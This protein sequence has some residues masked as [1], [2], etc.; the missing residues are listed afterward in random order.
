MCGLYLKRSKNLAVWLLLILFSALGFYTIPIMLYPVGILFTWLFFSA[1][2]EDIS[3]AY[4]RAGMIKYL[5]FAG[6]AIILLTLLFYLPAI[7]FSGLK[8]VLGNEYITR[9]NWKE[10]LQILGSR[11]FD[12]KKEWNLDVPAT[13]TILLAM[14]FLLSILLSRSI[15]SDKVPLQLAAFVF[16]TIELAIHRPNPWSRIWQFILPLYLIWAAAGWLAFINRLSQRRAWKVNPTQL[17]SIAGVVLLIGTSL[18]RSLAYYPDLKPYPEEVEQTV[19][20]LKDFHQEYDIVLMEPPRDVPIEYY[21]RLYDIPS[22]VFNR[23]Q[24]FKRAFIIVDRKSKQTLDSVF[25]YNGSEI[26]FFKLE[27]LQLI[28]QYQELDIYIC[29]SNWRLV[30]EAF[31]NK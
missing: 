6:F 13:G 10:Y 19:I 8:S 1:F 18:I 23:A 25:A 17:L 5:V 30:Q 14:G 7:R 21:A 9:A 24:P 3:P 12:L 28:E 22:E 27:T 20:L 4:T 29:D 31:N 16:I 2:L 11:W 26:F 15:A